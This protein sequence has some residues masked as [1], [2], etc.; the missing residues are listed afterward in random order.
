MGVCILEGSVL[1]IRLR[2]HPLKMTGLVLKG[3][4]TALGVVGFV[5]VMDLTGRKEWFDHGRFVCII[6]PAVLP[7]MYEVG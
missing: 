1:L 5:V 2:P 4:V 6:H 7:T 3:E